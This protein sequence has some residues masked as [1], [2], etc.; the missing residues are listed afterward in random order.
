MLLYRMQVSK[1][2]HISYEYRQCW[3][4]QCATSSGF[5]CAKE[6]MF[7]MFVI[8]LQLNWAPSM[9][10]M[11]ARNISHS[12]AATYQIVFVWCH[13]SVSHIMLW[14]WHEEKSL[15]C[16]ILHTCI[17]VTPAVL[18]ILQILWLC[19]TCARTSPFLCHGLC[20]F[21]L[22]KGRNQSVLHS[23]VHC[24]A[25]FNVIFYEMQIFSSVPRL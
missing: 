1:G 9:N 5:P 17:C 7:L 15:W 4:W 8:P 25:F 23:Y 2:W 16:K 24:Q 13:L 22:L 3:K 19:G 21:Y 14:R 20:N 12:V 18:K 11:S 10:R 6:C